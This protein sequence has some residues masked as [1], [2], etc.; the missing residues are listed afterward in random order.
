M[1]IVIDTREPALYDI[2]VRNSSVVSPENCGSTTS[3]TQAVLRKS[4]KLA[5]GITISMK[6]L[7]LG[8]IALYHESSDIPV[9]LFERKSL[10]DLL[11]SIKDGRYAEQSHR[12]IHTSNVHTHNIIYI[13]EGMF[14]QLRTPVERRMCLSAITSL[15]YY[16]GFSVFRTC[17]LSETAELILSMSTKIQKEQLKGGVP[18]FLRLEPHS[19]GNSK[20]YGGE[21]QGVAE[22]EGRSK[23]AIFGRDANSDGFA[24]GVLHNLLRPTDSEF[25]GEAMSRIKMPVYEISTPAPAPY[26]EVVH[27]VKKDNITPENI[28]EIILCT[29]PGISSTTAIEIMKPYTS[30]AHFMKELESRPELL[31]DIRV[32]KRKLGK[33]VVDNILRFLRGNPEAKP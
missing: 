25:S 31:A 19:Q 12:L 29:L 26:C 5:D 32:N 1:N 24:S 18:A 14:S 28:G 33:N 4:L 3:S 7:L 11:A 8:D 27:K 20:I 13:I 21:A 23:S 15:S 9:L 2:F 17:S 22:S 30:F 16:K 6:P 10:S